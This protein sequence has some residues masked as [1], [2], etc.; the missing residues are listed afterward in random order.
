LNTRSLIAK[1]SPH[2]QRPSSSTAQ[3]DGGK[4][5]SNGFRTRPKPAGLLRK[6]QMFA[7]PELQSTLNTQL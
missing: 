3:A 6:S 2:E 5:S 4:H 1:I 7:E